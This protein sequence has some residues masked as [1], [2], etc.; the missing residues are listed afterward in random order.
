MLGV[1]IIRNGNMNII[2][3]ILSCEIWILLQEVALKLNLNLKIKTL[4]NFNFQ[5]EKIK[6]LKKNGKKQETRKIIG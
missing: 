4:L 3:F 5:F 2:G 6:T 1:N